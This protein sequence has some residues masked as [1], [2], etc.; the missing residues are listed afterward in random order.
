MKEF[1]FGNGPREG[2]RRIDVIK[3]VLGLQGNVI[4]RESSTS[5]SSLE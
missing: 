2:R 1:K 4:Q 5:E 3:I